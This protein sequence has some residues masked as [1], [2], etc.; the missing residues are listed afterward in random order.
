M[1]IHKPRWH[2]HPHVRSSN[3]LSFG[4]RAA[5]VLK[6]WFGT[7]TALFAVGGVIALWIALQDTGA[8]WDVYPYILLNLVLSCVAAVQGIILQ[9][10]ANRGDRISSEL[11]MHTY[12]TGQQILQ[13]NESQSQLLAEIHKLQQQLAQLGEP[14]ANPID[15][16]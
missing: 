16:A 12:E 13:I 11:A 15:Q 8:R 10:S 5:D 14:P 4:E 6:H 3:D 2:E 1:V 7:W 9:I